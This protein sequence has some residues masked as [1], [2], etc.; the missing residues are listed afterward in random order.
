MKKFV[1][2]SKSFE[3]VSYI[4]PKSHVPLPNIPETL[5]MSHRIVFG[6]K[7]YVSLLLQFVV[8]ISVNTLD[9]L[10]Y[11]DNYRNKFQI[12]NSYFNYVFDVRSYQQCEKKNLLCWN[13]SRDW[14]AQYK[15]DIFNTLRPKK[16]AGIFQ[17]F[18]NALNENWCFDENAIE[19]CSPQSVQLTIFSIG[20]DNGLAL[21]RR[22]AITW[23]NDG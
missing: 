19:I 20:L 3:T 16:M 10:A 4:A 17:T 8:G 23:T 9:L 14:M 15:C 1:K 7:W 2:F 18:S 6:T 5:R 12:V 21:V 11:H 22:Q 13:Y